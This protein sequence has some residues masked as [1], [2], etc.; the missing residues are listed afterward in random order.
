[1]NGILSGHVHHRKYADTTLYSMSKRNLIEYI[2]E[3]E[4]NFINC[5]EELAWFEALAM[6]LLK[7]CPQFDVEAFQ[8]EFLKR[9]MD[10]DLQRL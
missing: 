10:N 6:E 7:H 9:G 2:R 5:D 4:H 3:T 8:K 1:M